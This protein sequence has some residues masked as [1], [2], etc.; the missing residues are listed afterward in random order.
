MIGIGETELEVLKSKID[1][2]SDIC[3]RIIEDDYSS[4][5]TA[6]KVLSLIILR[7]LTDDNILDNDLGDDNE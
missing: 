4:K 7:V 2:V 1:V 5:P 6:V 3:R